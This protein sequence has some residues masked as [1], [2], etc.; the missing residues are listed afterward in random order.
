MLF[1]SNRNNTML[2]VVKFINNLQKNTL[3]QYFK[4]ILAMNITQWYINT[5]IAVVTKNS[6]FWD[7]T[8]A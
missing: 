8:P 1:T 2:K 6:A 4:N 3:Q 5:H 7:V